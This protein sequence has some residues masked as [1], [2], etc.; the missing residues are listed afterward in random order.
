MDIFNKK[1]LAVALDQLNNANKTLLERDLMSRAMGVSHSGKRDLYDIYGYPRDP[2][3]H[4]I[5]LQA[6]RDGVANRVAFGVPQSCW[7]DGFKIVNNTDDK[8]ELLE[9]EIKEINKK[10]VPALERADI[11]NRMGKFSCLFVGVPDM[12][13]PSEPVGRVRGDA[14][15]S[16]YF[17]PFA[18]NGIQI[19]KWDTDRLSPRY[20]LPELYQLQTLGINGTEKDIFT[21]SIIAH[22]SR[23]IHVCENKLDSDVEGIPAL[24]PVLNNIL[25]LDKVCG[26]SAEAYFRNARGKTSFEIAPEFSAE[27]INNADAKNSFDEAAKK[28]TNDWQDQII[29]L[30]SKVSTHNTPHAS[31]LDTVKV[32]LWMISAQTKIPI[33]VL[34]GEG[35]GQL[36]G[37]EDKVSY[38]V[39]INDRQA[40]FC[41]TLATNAVEI[42]SNAGII[43]LPDVYCIDWPEQKATTEKEE[44]D[45]GLTK[46][47]TIK[48]LVDA[49]SAI[50]GD[51]VDLE[52]AFKACNL[53]EIDVE[54]VDIDREIQ[55]PALEI[56]SPAQ[57]AEKE[58]V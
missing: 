22:Y 48:N 21:E 4:D 53:E 25:N 15:K 10:L 23:V 19:H 3:F 2:E 47:Q 18:Y 6:V 39:I 1:K 35:G 14:I 43:T 11:L 36:A 34:T 12:Q 8:K 9:D 41:S 29:A 44:S 24:L 27:L 32:N 33:R 56:D 16:L 13:L 20:G 30:G 28:F 49:K 7:R 37:N 42:L 50:G 46:S 55:E 58:G 38:N 26:G 57:A 45:I 31:P 17:R 5:Y 52:D 51:G 54:D 40:L